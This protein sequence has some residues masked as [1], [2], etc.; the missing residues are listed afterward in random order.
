MIMPSTLPIAFFRRH[1][2]APLTAAALSLALLAGCGSSSDGETA[3][4]PTGA[5]SKVKVATSVAD[6]PCGLLSRETL[7]K[8]FSVPADKIEQIAVA[9]TCQWD[10]KDKTDR[11]SVSVTVSR[12]ADDAAEVREYFDRATRSMSGQE[13]SDAMAKVGAEAEARGQKNGLADGMTG[14]MGG[15]AGGKGIQFEDVSGI[16]DKARLQLADGRLNVL[17]GNLYFD[18]TAYHGP[19]MPMPDTIDL[20][21]IGKLSAQWEQETMPQRKAAAEQ[22]AKAVIAGL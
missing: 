9:S 17:Y 8:H 20:Q 15:K 22:I 4:A 10:W 18:V 2:A 3:A 7:A 16:G 6:D 12:V 11:M 1:S 13:V 14:A 5:T 19:K 21:S